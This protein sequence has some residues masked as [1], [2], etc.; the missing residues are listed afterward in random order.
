MMLKN[1]R[2]VKVP[3]KVQDRAMGCNITITDENFINILSDSA[4]L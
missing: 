3:F 4:N 2:C 1:H